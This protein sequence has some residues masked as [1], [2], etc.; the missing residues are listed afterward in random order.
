M[1]ARVVALPG[2]PIA[3]MGRGGDQAHYGSGGC[4]RECDAGEN[5]GPSGFQRRGSCRTTDD[6]Q[7]GFTCVPPTSSSQAR[8][9]ATPMARNGPLRAYLS[10]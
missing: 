5:C 10:E 9:T 7:V 2:S 1:G 3:D 8:R 4:E 6:C